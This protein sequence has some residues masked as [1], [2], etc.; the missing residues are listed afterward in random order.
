VPPLRER[1]E[2]V[3]VLAHHL[4][5]RVCRRLGKRMPGFAPGA[6]SELA[7]R[8]LRGNVRE[9]EN[10]ITRAVAL[11]P[12]GHPVE[13]AAFSVAPDRPVALPGGTAPVEGTPLFAAVEQT[14][15][16][17]VEA[18]LRKANGNMSRAAR[19]LGM[20]RPGLYKALERLGIHRDGTDE[21]G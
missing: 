10:E 6:L 19:E 21:K 15:R 13:A 3:P 11:T 18:V 20:S 1:P 16:R 17:I 12:E 8:P 4:L 5:G 14:E 7:S 2:D 9:L